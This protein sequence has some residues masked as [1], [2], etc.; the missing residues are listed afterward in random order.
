MK[1][2]EPQFPYKD[3]PVKEMVENYRKNFQH[4]KNIDQK[5]K[6]SG[7]IL[8]RFYSVPTFTGEKAYFQITKV[9]KKTVRVEYCEGVTEYKPHVTS[10]LVNLEDAQQAINSKDKLEKLFS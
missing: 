6:E 10:G 4:L 5:A 7:T 2:Y 3:L 8:Y 1:K 9:N